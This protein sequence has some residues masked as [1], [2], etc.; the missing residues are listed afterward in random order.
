MRNELE[1]AALRYAARG[2]AVIP[3]HSIRNGKCSCGNDDCSSPGKHPRTKTGLKEASKDQMVVADWWD[4][5]PDANIGIV[6]GRLSGIVV[7]DIDGEEGEETLRDLEA[8]FYGLLP[9]TWEQITGGG[10]RHLV[11]ERPIMEK[12]PNRVRFA[13]GLDIRGDDGYIVAAPSKHISGREYV[14]ELEH[15]P[16]F[17][18]I[19]PF[20]GT[21]MDVLVPSSPARQAPVDLPATFGQGERNNLLFKLGASLR[22]RGLS[23][24][25][26]MA[27]LSAENM[28]RCS[29]PL[30]E[31]EVAV[32][33]E[34]CCRYPMGSAQISQRAVAGLPAPPPEPI[35]GEPLEQLKG[36]LATA[37]YYA[38][39]VVGILDQ[40]D[41]SNSPTFFDAMAL[42]EKA[43][44]FKASKLK[45]ARAKYRARK[46]N[47]VVLKGGD[48]DLTLDKRL[49]D[50]PLKGLTMPGDWRISPAGT[51]YRYEDKGGEIG[52]LSACP[53]P[54]FP[55]ERLHNLDAGTEKLRVAFKRDAGWVD[56]VVDAAT[57][58][59]R[60]SIVQLSNY[61][62]QVTSENAKHLVTFL[63]EFATANREVMPMRK[64]TSRLGWIGT[65]QFAPYCEDVAY[66]GEIAY[67]FAYDAV[68]QSGE[69]ED[70]INYVT[71]IRESS[72]LLRAVLAAS[73]AAPLMGF[74]RYPPFF[75]HLWGPTETGKSAAQRLALS[76]WGDP[77]QLLK[78]LNTTMVGLERHAA[79]YHSL[80]L[81]LDEFQAL[82][83]R[84]DVDSLIYALCLGKSKGR[85][86]TGGGVEIEREWK[87]LFLTSGE[88][89]M[90]TSSMQGGA[91]NRVLEFYFGKEDWA[92]HDA[93]DATIF[94][95][96][97]Y[98]HAGRAYISAIAELTNGQR[99]PVQEAWQMFRSEIRDS[100]YTD[101][102][103][104]NVAMLA[105]GDYMASR[106]IFQQPEEQAKAEAMVLAMELLERLDKAETTDPIRRAWAYVQDWVEGNKTRFS[107][108]Y[109][110]SA[111]RLGFL[112]YG[113]DGGKD[114]LCILPSAFEAALKEAGF[115][116]RASIK[117]FADRG[118]LRTEVDGTKVRYSVRRK[119]AGQTLRLYALW[120]PFLA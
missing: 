34:S 80:P 115:S 112:Q 119:I 29:P 107:M 81:A 17:V 46:K 74:V 42:V 36:L 61:G 48:E 58:A 10:G 83:R 37:P 95:M 28:A 44:G 9:E 63:S 65:Q 92:G 23:E 21:W 101:K 7:I 24:T 75:V 73:F 76:V 99:A 45:A 72:T 108:D 78:T 91:Q 15:D 102:Y 82:S 6:T 41:E 104:N 25:A 40:L 26:L 87:T 18:P 77:E 30:T 111:P 55:I 53:H 11:F 84:M 110:G 88:E 32:I 13:P 62:L 14:W 117:G 43:D 96:D 50:I 67:R 69:L 49:P 64:S 85:G 106:F 105:L 71:P 66:D 47:L 38:D 5:W 33:A 35:P 94:T 22:A 116:A 1:R 120:Y 60:A 113:I 20:P 59:S 56:V 114:L 12:C 90:S 109:D 86:T 93:A 70:W 100:E 97:T 2:M 98:G 4:R 27:A 3:L 16:E 39:E 118:Y 54:V 79:F 52:K 89:P 8:E 51:I 103:I 19:A 68:R 31:K 57:A